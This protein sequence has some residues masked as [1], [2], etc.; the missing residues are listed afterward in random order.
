MIIKLLLFNLKENEVLPLWYSGVCL[1]VCCSVTVCSERFTPFLL[2][3]FPSLHDQQQEQ[4]IPTCEKKHAYLNLV[5]TLFAHKHGDTLS[6]TH[7][8]SRGISDMLG[9]VPHPKLV[10]RFVRPEQW[11]CMYRSVSEMTQF[12]KGYANSDSNVPCSYG[13]IYRNAF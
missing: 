12:L 9:T 13:S 1:C 11:S 7:I 4:Y 10:V 2:C 5:Y 3:P 8:S 6:H